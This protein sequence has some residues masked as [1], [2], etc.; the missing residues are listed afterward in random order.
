M[1]GT[2]E[3]FTVTFFFSRALFLIS[4]RVRG[5]SAIIT[6]KKTLRSGATLTH[7]SN[8]LV[9]WCWVFLQIGRRLIGCQFIR[10]SA[11]DGSIFFSS[12]S[13]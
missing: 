12:E 2:D 8:H 5:S 10:F 6:G 11:S 13:S 7:F 9:F 1:D 4:S 3:N